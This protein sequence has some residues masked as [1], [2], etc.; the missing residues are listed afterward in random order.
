VGNE[1]LLTNEKEQIVSSVSVILTSYVCKLILLNTESQHLTK[2][3]PQRNGLNT[4]DVALLSC[5]T[6]CHV[7]KIA[8]PVYHSI[9][10]PMRF[11]LECV[12]CT[13]QQAPSL[14][15]Y[16]TIEPNLSVSL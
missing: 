8:E 6:S 15:S 3:T 12:L 11:M 14:M 7:A 2:I 13:T 1:T 9:T 16:Q 4:V 10:N 5:K